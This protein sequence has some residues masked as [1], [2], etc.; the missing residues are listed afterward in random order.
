MFSF[1]LTNYKEWA[2]AQARFIG[3]VLDTVLAFLSRQAQKTVLVWKK[4]T[5]RLF[6]GQRARS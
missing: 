1:E 3:S 2:S 6:V 4:K 5:R